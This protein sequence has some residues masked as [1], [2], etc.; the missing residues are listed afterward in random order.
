MSTLHVKFMHFIFQTMSFLKGKIIG[1]N[2]LF[3]KIRIR[4]RIQSFWIRHT[5]DTRVFK[6]SEQQTFEFKNVIKTN[7]IFLKPRNDKCRI[8]KALNPRSS[9]L[10]SIKIKIIHLKP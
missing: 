1:L 3:S 10:K 5:G 4:I 2:F 7:I 8:F 9:P 6:T